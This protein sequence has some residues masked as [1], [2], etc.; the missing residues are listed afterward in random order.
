[1][2]LSRRSLQ[3]V[4][5]LTVTAGPFGRNVF[6]AA[7]EPVEDQPKLDPRL[8]TYFAAKERHANLLKQ[9]LKFFVGNR[10]LFTPNEMAELFRISGDVIRQRGQT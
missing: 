6:A 3:W 9:R 10:N 4:L 5:L 7:A 8:Q 2:N 1:M